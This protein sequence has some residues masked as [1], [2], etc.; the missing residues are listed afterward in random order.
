MRR[1]FTSLVY[2]VDGMAGRDSRAEVKRLATLL[3]EKWWREYSE[4][5][6]FLQVWMSLSVVRA[7]TLLLR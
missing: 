2:T 5:V 6:G 7:N 1:D 3:A 4:M